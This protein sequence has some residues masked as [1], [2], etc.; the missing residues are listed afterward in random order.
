MSS[1]AGKAAK[2]PVLKQSHKHGRQTLVLLVN[3]VSEERHR[4]LL[5][6]A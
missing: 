4:W 5:V 3:A 2:S 1:A 6:G